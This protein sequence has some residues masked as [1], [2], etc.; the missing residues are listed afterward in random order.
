M[1]TGALDQ[2]IVHEVWKRGVLASRIPMLRG[3]YQVFLWA[4]FD[5]ETDTDALLTRAVAHRGVYV[6]GSAFYID[7]RRTNIARLTFSALSHPR[8]EE[9]I[10]HLATAVGEESAARKSAGASATV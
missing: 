7:G 4:S 3:F 10:R 1:C 2:R 5:D 9:G 6:G 8:V